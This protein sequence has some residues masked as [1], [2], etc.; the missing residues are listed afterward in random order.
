MINWLGVSACCLW[1]WIFFWLV[2]MWP[3]LHDGFQQPQLP[4]RSDLAI[5][6]D[7]KED[8]PKFW[9]EFPG[10]SV[11]SSGYLWITSLVYLLDISLQAVHHRATSLGDALHSFVRHV[12]PIWLRLY[13]A[14]WCMLGIPVHDKTSKLVNMSCHLILSNMQRHDM[15]NLFS[16]LACL[17]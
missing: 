16:C 3:Q 8:F 5:W 9:Q 10:P 15:W 14:R 6:L 17:L 1:L 13:S 7:W 4:L 12:Q 2:C 11:T